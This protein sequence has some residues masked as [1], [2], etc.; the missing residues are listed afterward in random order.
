[1]KITQKDALRVEIFPKNSTSLYEDEISEPLSI[2]KETS[3]DE[4]THFFNQTP[5]L[6]CI[7]DFEGYIIQLNP[8]WAT[9]MGWSIEELQTKSFL[10]FVHPDDYKATREKI[11]SHAKGS[12]IILFENRCRHRDGTYRWLRWNARPVP[13]RKR[14]YASARDVTRQ[15]WLERENLEVVDREKE[16]LGRELHDGLCQ[17]LAGIAA[18]GTALSR[19]LA[20]NS[21]SSASTEAAEIS[22]LLSEAIGEARDLAQGLG[23]QGL[24]EIGIDGAL[25]NLA[26][27]T[28]HRFNI[29]CSIVCSNPIH[30]LSQKVEAHLY[31]IAQESINNAMTHGRA[32]HIQITL[33]YDDIEGLLYI[34][35][36]GVGIA[37][38]I[39]LS[40]GIGL[41]TMQHRVHLIGGNLT[42]QQHDSGGTEVKCSFPNNNESKS[43]GHDDS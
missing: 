21:E 24:S 7:V 14:Y 30:R 4:Y 28:Q 32:K 37:K 12:D 33:E 40:D 29:S 35:D 11:Y 38:N 1:M 16:R 9:H 31:R 6:M 13:G 41:N 39:K 36:D 34:Q 25:A 3:E 5:E 18:M 15:K 8:A 42:V 26:L 10:D 19:K 23:P 17:T 20:V 27:N 43:S 22:R 2:R